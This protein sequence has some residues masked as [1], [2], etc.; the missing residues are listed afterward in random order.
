MQVIRDFV[1]GLFSV[2]KITSSPL[3]YRYQY[4][5]SA[6][7]FHKDWMNIAGD[8]NSIIGKLEE[9]DDGNKRRPRR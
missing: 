2:L 7:A 3:L 6:E 9:K 8:I 1:T 4:R 5:N